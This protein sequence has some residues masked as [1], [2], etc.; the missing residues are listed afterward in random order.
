MD[1][2]Q[3]EA[4]VDLGPGIQALKAA[5]QYFLRLLD[6]VIDGVSVNVE[7]LRCVLDASAVADVAPEG[8]CDV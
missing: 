4:D 8:D 6:L 1:I 3:H 5:A 7:L 2:V